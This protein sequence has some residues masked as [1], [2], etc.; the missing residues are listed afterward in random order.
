MAF[1][2]GAANLLGIR[3]L[4]RRLFNKQR[5]YGQKSAFDRP[6]AVALTAPSWLKAAKLR[7]AFSNGDTAL[8]LIRRADLA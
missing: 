8:C 2:S 1:A 7:Q 6:C 4:G 5:A 3:E